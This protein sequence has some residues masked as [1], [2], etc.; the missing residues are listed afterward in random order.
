MTPVHRDFLVKLVIVSAHVKMVDPVIQSLECASVHPES[1]EITV[2][3]AALLDSTNQTVTS[4]AHKNVRVASVI[5]CLASVNVTLA[6]LVLHVTCLARR[7]H[8]DQI[9]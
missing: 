9:V 7:L 2:K 8:M 5:G 3:M 4:L 1:K 6:S